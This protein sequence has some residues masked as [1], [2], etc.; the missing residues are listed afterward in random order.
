MPQY[1][2]LQPYFDIAAEVMDEIGRSTLDY[3][4]DRA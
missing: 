2:P 4:P 3:D 1:P